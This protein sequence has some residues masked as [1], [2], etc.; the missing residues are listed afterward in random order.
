V[1]DLTPGSQAT[2]EVWRDR[3]ERE[4]VV[5]ITGDAGAKVADAEVSSGHGTLGLSVRPLTP[6][7]RREDDVAG[8]VMVEGISGAAARAGLQPGDVVLSLNGTPVTGVDQLRGLVGKAGK[9]V[10]VLVQRGQARIFLPVA[11]G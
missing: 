1:A 11:I 5:G 4:M 9:H 8:G 6:E 7:E 3:R 2:L 10:A